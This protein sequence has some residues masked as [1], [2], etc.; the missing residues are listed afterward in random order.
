MQTGDDWL[1]VAGVGG[2]LGHRESTLEGP[3][4]VQSRLC[5]WSYLIVSN[6]ESLI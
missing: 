4:A 3:S 1:R 2:A 5:G 6:R